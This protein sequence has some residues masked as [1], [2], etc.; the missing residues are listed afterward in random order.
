M[1]K[2]VEIS[3]KN[4]SFDISRLPFPRW[5]NTNAV[6]TDQLAT[7]VHKWLAEP[8]S[9][10]F[11]FAYVVDSQFQL[12]DIRNP[13]MQNDIAFKRHLG[14]ARMMII[15]L[16]LPALRM[17][18][19]HPTRFPIL[20]N[21]LVAKQT[22][23]I[24]LAGYG[25]GGVGCAAQ[26][27]ESPPLPVFSVSAPLDCPT[28]FPLPNFELVKL[29]LK[30][31][32]RKKRT[33]VSLI[34]IPKAVWRGSPTGMADLEKNRR[35]RLCRAALKYPSLMD[36]KFVPHPMLDD[37]EEYSD[38]IGSFTTYERYQ[39]V[40]DIDGNG[41]SSRFASLLCSQQAIIKVQPVD[42]DYFFP[43]LK[44]GVHYFPVDYDL[45]DL[46]NATVTALNQ[47]ESVRHANTFC[48]K[49]LTMDSLVRTTAAILEAYASILI[50]SDRNSGVGELL[51]NAEF[52]GNWNWQNMIFKV[53]IAW[54]LRFNW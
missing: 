4:V 29:A 41:W 1:E 23:L 36:V 9:V 35:V 5:V 21:L 39:A 10:P 16:I 24:W 49:H 37:K 47:T 3:R 43:L 52:H 45:K 31:R 17:I 14:R 26:R 34:D 19:H 33:R 8:D 44:P 30:L 13:R 2:F 51:R 22:S 54:K 27:G 6:D 42:V 20:T 38:L 40:I 50:P 48:E 18:R 25:D 28:A 15:Y 46:A 11:E 7:A 53:K 32:H 12:Y